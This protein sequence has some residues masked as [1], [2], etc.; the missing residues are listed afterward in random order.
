MK[1]YTNFILTVIAVLM[2]VSIFEIE[3]ITPANASW[4][5]HFEFV[6]NQNE[7]ILEMLEHVIEIMESQT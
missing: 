2:M 1:G 4:Q 3:I 5:E 7:K 6:W